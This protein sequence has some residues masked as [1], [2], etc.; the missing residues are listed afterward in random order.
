[1]KLK[2]DNISKT[3]GNKQILKNVTFIAQEKDI[4]GLIGDNG[5]G[6]TTT[7]KCIFQEYLV[8]NGNILIDDKEITAQDLIQ[9]AFFPDQNNFPKNYSVYDYCKY[10]Y[11]LSGLKGNFNEQLE[12]ILDALDLKD[13]KKAKFKLL[14]SG[15]QKRALLAAIL[16][17][18]PK[19]LFLD[20]PT[21]NL[22]VQSRKEFIELLKMLAVKKDIIIVITSHEIEELDRLINKI[23]ILNH[24]QVIYE[25][26]FDNSK[27]NLQ[28][29]YDNAVKNRKTKIDKN[30]IERIF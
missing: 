10:N 17:T 30:K 19:I 29:I 1:M 15:M 13:Y 9:M 16:I 26:N 11:D 23:V 7:I 24:G 14:S 2:V 28:Q 20:E 21:A 8:Q 5:S 6:K 4:I 18:R 3:I 27:D 25:N 22:D 12:L